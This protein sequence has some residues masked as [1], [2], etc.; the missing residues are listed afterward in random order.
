M[1]FFKKLF[2]GS[3][4]ASAGRFYSFA[5]QCGR[6]GELI[7]GQVNLSNDLS[8]D[9]EGGRDVYFVRK[10]L[11]GS[12]R[13]FQQIQVELKFDV[14]RRLLDRQVAG[15]TFSEAAPAPKS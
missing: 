14:E 3:P 12:G 11:M 1:G 7:P 15:G 10:T 2:P 13:C 8:V 6:C 4:A 5:V 9:Y